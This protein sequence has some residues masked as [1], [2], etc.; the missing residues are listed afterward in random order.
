MAHE[1]LAGYLAWRPLVG[2][3]LGLH[4]YD[5]QVTDFSQASIEAE[6]ARLERCDAQLDRFNPRPLSPAA[7]HDLRLLRAAVRR[8]RFDFE[9]MRS[10]TGNPM[11]Y[12]GALDV[13]VYLK[14]D[15][16]PLE[17]D[18]DLRVSLAYGVRDA[19]FWREGVRTLLGRRAQ[20]C[21]GASLEECAR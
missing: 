1:Y 3:S 18:H 13:N 16:A 11:T 21:A 12:A 19:R 8:E 2:V 14:R 4:E 17:E 10:Y 5:G 20:V 7:R 15:F 9:V 6:R